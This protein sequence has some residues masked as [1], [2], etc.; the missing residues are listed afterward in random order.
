[1]VIPLNVEQMKICAVLIVWMGNS[2]TRSMVGSGNSFAGKALGVLNMSQH[3]GI[4]VGS[5]MCWGSAAG[6]SGEVI[7][8]SAQPGVSRHC[9]R[10]EH[11]KDRT[12]CNKTEPGLLYWLLYA[13]NTLKVLSNSSLACAYMCE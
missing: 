1:M 13:T 7:L 11:S 9:L 12:H 5:R 4:P 2:W 6:G 8:P 3:L 10:P